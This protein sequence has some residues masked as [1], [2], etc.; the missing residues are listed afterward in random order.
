[1]A[2]QTSAG[3]TIGISAGLPATDDAAGY[4]A[5]T[6]TPI[7][8]VTD[9][10]EYGKVFN[11][12][13][14]IPIATRRTEKFKGSFNEGSISMG[15]GE[16]TSDAGQILLDTAVES[17]ANFSFEITAQDGDIDY[18]QAKVMSKTVNVGSVDSIRSSTVQL[19]IT[20]G[21]VDA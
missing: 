5:L 15:I 17:D 7:G 13:T 18:F 4:G 8:E 11:L 19:E 1:M 12:V 21:I 9:L 20:S 3:T 10:G 6:F 2:V 16:D 14:H